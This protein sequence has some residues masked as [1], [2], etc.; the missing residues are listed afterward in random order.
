MA[1]PRFGGHCLLPAGGQ[2]S[3][4]RLR[5]GVVFYFRRLQKSSP[6]PHIFATASRSQPNFHP[7]FSSS[8]RSAPMQWANICARGVLAAGLEVS[9]IG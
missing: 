7:L 1:G 5:A 8:A 3:A 2:A 6:P 4:W 9:D